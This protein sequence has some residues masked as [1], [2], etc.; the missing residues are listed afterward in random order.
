MR[1]PWMRQEPF[2]ERRVDARRPELA[3]Q[4]GQVVPGIVDGVAEP[5]A[6]G[7]IGH[8]LGEFR[9]LR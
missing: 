9:V 8:H 6:A 2:L 4:D 5:E 7:M 3:G 1:T